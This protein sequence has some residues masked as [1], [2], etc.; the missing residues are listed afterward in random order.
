MLALRTIVSLT[1]LSS[2]LLLPLGA[3]AATS[4]FRGVNWADPRDNFQSGVVYI[5]GLSS[6]DT[7]D[8]ALA[9]GTSVMTQFKSKLGANAVRMPI[10]EPTVSSYW[11]NYTGA[12]DA[13][14][15]NGM[16]VLCYWDSAKTNKPADMNA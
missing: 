8:S 5:A 16:V 13:V 3:S 1:A 2:L 12:I 9:T 4:Q 10:N 14:V 15:S 6:S 7:Y 11:S